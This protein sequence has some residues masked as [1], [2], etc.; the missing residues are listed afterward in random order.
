MDE[1]DGE[2]LAEQGAGDGS[3]SKLGGAHGDASEGEDNAV[4]MESMGAGWEEG[5]GVIE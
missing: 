3:R 4:K 5:R 2:N 1:G